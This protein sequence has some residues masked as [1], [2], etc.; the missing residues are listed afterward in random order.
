MLAF[1]QASWPNTLVADISNTTMRMP[2]SMQPV[3]A[4]DVR[5]PSWDRVSA[6]EAEARG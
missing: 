6:G 4:W 5:A 2:Q 1:Q 3:S